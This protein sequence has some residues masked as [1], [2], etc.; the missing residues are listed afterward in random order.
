M[1]Y[2]RAI[3]GKDGYGA[4]SLILLHIRVGTIATLRERGAA[5]GGDQGARAQQ[6]ANGA[7]SV[8][9]RQLACCTYYSDGLCSDQGWSFTLILSRLGKPQ[10]I[11]AKADWLATRAAL[12]AA[13]GETDVTVLA[14]LTEALDSGVVHVHWFTDDGPLEGGATLKGGLGSTETHALLKLSPVFAGLI[15]RAENAK[16]ATDDAESAS[17]F[18]GRGEDDAI[19][20]LDQQLE[21]V[22]QQ[23]KEN[24][25]KAARL[26][27]L[28]VVS[29]FALTAFVMFLFSR[30]MLAVGLNDHMKRN[31]SCAHN[32]TFDANKYCHGK[33]GNCDSTTGCYGGHPTYMNLSGA[34]STCAAT[35]GCVGVADGGCTGGPFSLCAAF[36]PSSQ[37]S[38]VCADPT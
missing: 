15:E 3:G 25:T 9:D 16:N 7:L 8:I 28:Y 30:E 5:H 37:G 17:I 19:G 2:R 12:L 29:S 11:V 35:A 4:F 23:F 22:V 24:E 32:W 6:E 31:H 13:S 27:L 36:A 21:A 26:K 38:C 18:A 1:E 14:T 10:G 20:A 34:E 33:V